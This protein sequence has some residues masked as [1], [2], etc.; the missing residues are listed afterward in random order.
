MRIP[1]IT[2]CLNDVIGKQTATFAVVERFSTTRVTY[3]R[4]RHIE[5]VDVEVRAWPSFA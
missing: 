5:S 1:K 4:L 3:H 2:E